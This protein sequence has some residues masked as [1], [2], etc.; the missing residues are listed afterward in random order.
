MEREYSVEESVMVEAPI[1]RVWE[2][3]TTPPLIKQWFFGVD[4]ETTWTVGSPIVHRGEYQGRPYE[5]NGVILEFQPPR[6]LVHSHWSPASGLS[7]LPENHERVA[8]NLSQAEDGTIL[9]ISESNL[10]NREAKVTSEQ[11]WRMVL[12]NLKEL[13]EGGP[14]PEEPR[15]PPDR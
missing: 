8:W 4:T 3:I 9:T 14:D 1:E 7:D 15:R 11:S 2:A 12:Q 6:V 13:L 5:D 10:A